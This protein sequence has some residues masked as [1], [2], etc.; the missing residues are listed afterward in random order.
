MHAAV[1]NPK[2]KIANLKS[3]DRSHP[4]HFWQKRNGCVPGVWPVDQQRLADE[5]I[6]LDI[7]MRSPV[8][9]AVPGVPV[10]AVRTL[11]AVIAERKELIFFQREANAPT[12]PLVEQARLRAPLCWIA[13]N[14]VNRFGTVGPRIIRATIGRRDV[15]L[16]AE[17]L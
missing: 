8:A 11:R 14:I 10:S 12:V 6:A 17:N 13:K 1:G 16:V 9:P 5:Q 4:A 3:P 7:V 15:I 2:S